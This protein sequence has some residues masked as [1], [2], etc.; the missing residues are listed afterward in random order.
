M[1]A[2]NFKVIVVGGGPVGLTAAQAL[3]RAN[4]DFVLLESRPDIVIDAGSNLVLSTIGLR[5]LDQLDLL[6]DINSASSPL[7]K[8]VRIDHKGRDI[9]DVNIFTHINENHGAYPRAISRHD[10]TKTLYESLPAEARAKLLPKKKL[11][12]IATTENGVVVTCADGSSYEGSIVIGADGAHS[13]VRKH[14]RRLALLEEAAAAAAPATSSDARTNQINEEQPFLTT[15]RCI[16]IRFPTAKGLQ[17]GDAIETHGSRTTVQL[18]AGDETSVIGVYERLDAPTRNP[19]YRYSDADMDAFIE[20]WGHLPIA[21]LRDQQEQHLTMR[22]A[23]TDRVGAGLVNLEEGVVQHWSLG[24]R[25]VLVGDAA[26]KFT[27]STGAG[28]NNGIVDVVALANELHRTLGGADAPLPSQQEAALAAAFRR[29]QD[30]RFAAVTTGCQTSRNATDAATWSTI[31]HKFVDQN[32]MSIAWLQRYMM[33]KAAPQ[34]ARTPVLNF[35]ESEEQ[36]VG[37]V[38]W[39]QSFAPVSVV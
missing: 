29:Y 11:S 36:M 27:P 1:T 15:Y 23:Y 35:V 5:V 19:P 30:Q 21:P 2:T 6:N 4:I 16:W 26:H 32:V 24:G 13:A 33:T 3:Y 28:C 22:D 38:P 39:A 9:G 10:L 18:F 34:I 8:F 20:Q 12:N 17:P 37:K 7:Q 14:M 31:V 25:I